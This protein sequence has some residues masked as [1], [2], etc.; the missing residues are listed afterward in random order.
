MQMLSE[1]FTIR[2]NSF[3]QIYILVAKI[4]RYSY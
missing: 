4:R 3:V 2:E 1:S